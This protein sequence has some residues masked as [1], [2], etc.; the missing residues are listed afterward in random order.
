[1]MKKILDDLSG[2]K[3]GRKTGKCHIPLCLIPAFFLSIMMTTSCY[4]DPAIEGAPVSE[5]VKE[6]N[7][8]VVR[9][10]LM[11]KEKKEEVKRMTKVT[12]NRVFSEISGRPEYRIG[13]LD[14]VEIISHIGE[15]A[16]TATVTVNS[17]GNIS[18]SFIDNL[19][20]D[21]LTSSQLD[22][23]LTKRLSSYLRH[24][25]VDIFIKEFKSKSAMVTG[26]LTS[27]QAPSFSKSASGKIYLRGKTTLLD[28]ISLAGGYNVD[29]DIRR[30]QLIRGGDT[31]I[32]NLFDIMSRGDSGQ[33]VI[34]DADDV[35]D[36]PELPL[37]GDRVYVLG[38]VDEQGI[39]PLKQAQDLLGALA[40]AGNFNSVAKEENTLIVRGRESGEE[41]LVMM[42]DVNAILRKADI[43]Q[44]IPLQ[45]GDLIYVPPRRIGDINRWIS[46]VLPL[47][48]IM[49]YPGDFAARYGEGFKIN[50]N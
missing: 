2:K 13:P 19:F 21:G 39:Y 42:A 49:L 25:R 44:N 46:N 37:F 36:V 24:P 31:Y 23:L 8:E 30:V 33:N 16:N 47:L 40:L 34:I 17:Q 41:P 43:S 20:V 15:K 10:E 27:L 7:F 12:E 26:Y 45:N 38:A 35:V 1:M 29:A 50:V 3:V 6:G 5:L 9:P 28:L 4:H 14:V 48:D 22:A 32:I 11:S 18:Y